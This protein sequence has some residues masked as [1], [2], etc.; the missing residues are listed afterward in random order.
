ML[1]DNITETDFNM[2]R[3]YQKVTQCLQC[4]C[5]HKYE[6]DN[7]DKFRVLLLEKSVTKNTFS[8]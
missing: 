7:W 4:S 2:K 5:T 8:W 1:G 3:I 6:K